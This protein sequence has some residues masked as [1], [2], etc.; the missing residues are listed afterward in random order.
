[1]SWCHASSILNSLTY[2]W[3]QT[4]SNNSS[5][6]SWACSSAVFA[7]KRGVWVLKRKCLCMKYSNVLAIL[8]YF[9]LILPIVRHCTAYGCSNRS[10]KVGWENLSW[11]THRAKHRFCYMARPGTTEHLNMLFGKMC[12]WRYVSPVLFAWDH[13]FRSW[14]WPNLVP[15]AF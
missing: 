8:S 11:H 9:W 4:S 7:W 3:F 14:S 15:R 13:Y 1:M 6:Y 2:D 12:V 10:N 5:Y